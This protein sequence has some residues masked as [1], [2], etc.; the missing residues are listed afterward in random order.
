VIELLALSIDE[1]HG[2]QRQMSEVMSQT[3]GYVRFDEMCPAAELVKF[4]VLYLVAGW[5]ELVEMQL[6][7]EWQVSEVT[8]QTA[9]YVCFAEVCPAAELVKFVVVYLVVGWA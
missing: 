1:Q 5:A 3:A 7:T 8:S 9:G 6:A 2:Q 4:V